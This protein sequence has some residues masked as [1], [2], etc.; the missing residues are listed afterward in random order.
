M[1]LL[2]QEESRTATRNQGES[3]GGVNWGSRLPR[4]RSEWD[5]FVSAGLLREIATTNCV[6]KIRSQREMIEELFSGFH[7]ANKKSVYNF[8]SDNFDLV[9]VLSDAPEMFRS[10]V[11]D[12]SLALDIYTDMDEGW[13]RL[14]LV[15]APANGRGNV[16]EIEGVLF[17]EWV[18]SNKG[19]L[20]GRVSLI[21]E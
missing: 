15:V 19:L 11:G 10:L 9:D 18:I 3:W 14:L 1:Q 20:S 16:S 2:E 12:V 8:L 21:V 17:E 6:V 7:V 5:I 13:K 4:S